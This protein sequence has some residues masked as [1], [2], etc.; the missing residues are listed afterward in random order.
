MHTHGDSWLSLA[1]GLKLWFVY[2]PGGPPT[3]AA[4]EQ[5]VLPPAASYFMA[6][7][8]A[9]GGGGGMAGGAARPPRLLNISGSDR[10]QVCLQ[11]PGE[12]VYIPALW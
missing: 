1:H 9:G 8:A 3:A 5:L 11:R 4:Y 12:T 10:P 2:P 6:G 7:G